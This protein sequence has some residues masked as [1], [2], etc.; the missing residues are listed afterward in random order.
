MTKVY[1]IRGSIADIMRTESGGYRWTDAEAL[2][3]AGVLYR[4]A[5]YDQLLAKY[6]FKKWYEEKLLHY[7]DSEEDFAEPDFVTKFYQSA[8]EARAASDM[9]KIDMMTHAAEAVTAAPKSPVFSTPAHIDAR[10]IMPVYGKIKNRYSATGLPYFIILRNSVTL[11]TSD[12]YKIPYTGIG[13]DCVQ[14]AALARH[15][16]ASYA[17]AVAHLMP[18]SLASFDILLTDFGDYHKLERKFQYAAVQGVIDN[19][20][21]AGGTGRDVV[22]EAKSKKL[23]KLEAEAKT[24][25]TAAEA[26]AKAAEARA[27]AKVHHAA[28]T[29]KAR[30]E[31][32]EAAAKAA[33]ARAAAAPRSITADMVKTGDDFEALLLRYVGKKRTVKIIQYRADGWSWEEVSADI[34][35]PVKTCQNKYFEAVKKLQRE[36]ISNF[37]K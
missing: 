12:N 23:A 6:L 17:R 14:A 26:A 21:N 19:D 16:Y 11:A 22:T 1:K 35:L 28:A 25:W 37:L 32:A 13:M 7:F 31:A 33:E 5:V 10:D 15:E 24:R 18:L 8:A 30:A 20:M 4:P 9:L 34:G 36:N 2:A 3:K 29:A 27:A